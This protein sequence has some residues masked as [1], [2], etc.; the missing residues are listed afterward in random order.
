MYFGC[1]WYPEHWDKS[2]WAEDLRLMR[3]AHMNVVRL[4]EFAWSRLEPR[5]GRFELDWLEAA[6][7][8]A[9]A[10]GLKSV[11]GTPTAAPPAWLTQAY[12]E[13]LR[14]D[15][16]G[17]PARHG[18]R[19]HFNPASP[20]YLTFCRRIAE[21]LA[22]RFGRN[23]NV[24]GWQIDNEYWA[25]SYDPT[26]AAQFQQFLRDRY[27]TLDNLNARW[28]AS[29]W[30]QEYSDWS[31]VQI[32]VDRENPCLGLEF[33]RFIAHTYRKYQ[34]NQIEAIRRHAEPRQFITHNFHGRMDQVD[35]H[36]L[37]EDLD[38]AGWDPYIGRG[39][40]E[41]VS[42]GLRHD[43][44]RG[45]KRRNFWVLETQPGFV[46]WAPVNNP[47]DRGETRA[48]AW[49]LVGHG[50]DAVLYWQW[51][52]ALG[53]QEQYHGNIVGPHGQPRPLYAEV[54]QTGGEFARAAEVLRGTTPQTQVAILWSYENRWAINLQRHHQDFDPNA[55]VLSFYRPLRFLGMDVDLAHTG[56]PLEQYRVVIAPHLHLF[57]DELAQRLLAYVRQGGHLL[58]GPRSGMK[59][60]FNALLPAWQPGPLLAQALGGRVEEFY[61]LEQEV[62]VSGALGAGKALIFAEWLT[63][64]APDTEALLRY[65]GHS[66]LHEKVAFLTRRV[67]RGR[68][69]YLGAWLDDELMVHLAT[70][71]LASCG[72]S[73]P[74]GR[75]PE[76][77]ELCRRVGEGREVWIFVNH[78]AELRSCRLRGTMKD[79][80]AGG[81][82]GPNVHLGPREVAVLMREKR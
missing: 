61:A 16:A 22:R 31:Q 4:G 24:I 59:D 42:Q 40:L 46:C 34:L 9:G 3:E 68:L 8:L 43:A 6:V 15:P 39:H 67:D 38:L 21:E 65:T 47:M 64:Q 76:G 45:L 19:C 56:A 7:N 80:L 25:F 57:T 48:M 13:V 81:E 60:Q 12:P 77:V 70:W 62:P 10:E 28:T 33:R 58:L 55:H 30:S 69:S 82:R 66:W 11:V 79:V 49:H 14:V 78:A 35:P 26:T 75:L 1:A 51:R 37:A 52:S 23:P 50:A 72:L 44:V 20:K 32:G 18:A 53:G 27:G 71:L 73:A 29:Y 36:L 5:E 74:L 41:F 2:R 54:A 63:P 17:R